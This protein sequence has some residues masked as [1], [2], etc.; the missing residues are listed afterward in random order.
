MPSHFPGPSRSRA[1]THE[2]ARQGARRP[3]PLNIEG[4]RWTRDCNSSS[5]SNS[6]AARGQKELERGGVSFR[7]QE[8][9]SARRKRERRQQGQHLARRSGQRERGWRRRRRAERHSRRRRRRGS[10]VGN[11]GARRGRRGERRYTRSP[12]LYV[13]NTSSRAEE[14]EQKAPAPSFFAPPPP[15]PRISRGRTEKRGSRGPRSGGSERE[16]ERVVRDWFCAAARQIGRRPAADAQTSREMY[17]LYIRCIC[18]EP[19]RASFSLPRAP[20]LPRGAPR[21]KMRRRWRVN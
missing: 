4:L 8:R 15:P 20:E 1:H 2:R 21:R 7:R 14:R 11:L 16:P 6:S 13:H 3:G 10:L 5:S 17:I 12:S 18:A 9:R 19:R